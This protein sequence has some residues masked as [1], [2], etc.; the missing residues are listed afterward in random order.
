M[1]NAD[2]FCYKSL[3]A[4][5][6][7]LALQLIRYDL[8]SLANLFDFPGFDK[9]LQYTVRQLVKSTLVLPERI[10]IRLDTSLSLSQIRFPLPQVKFFFY[11]VLYV[12]ILI[13]VV[14]DLG[15]VTVNSF[16][17]DAFCIRVV[18]RPKTTGPNP[19]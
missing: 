12:L 6:S 8:T 19:K 2:R 10:G 18:N 11:D 5:L 4:F 14:S 17:I 9:I 7:D 3:D 1:F 15:S 16:E 13:N